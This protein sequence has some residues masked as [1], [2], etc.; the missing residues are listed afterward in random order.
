MFPTVM[1]KGEADVYNFVSEIEP[2]L[3]RRGKT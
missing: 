1:E 3:I 2:F